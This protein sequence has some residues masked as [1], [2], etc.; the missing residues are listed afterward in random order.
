LRNIRLLVEFDGA[1]FSGWQYQPD[2]RTVQGE[3]QRAV[4]SVT[5][6]PATVYGCSRTDAGVSAR[7]YVA[8]FHAETPLPPDRLRL[9]LNYHLPPEILVKDAVEAP[10]GFHAR[11]SARSKTYV[12][13]LLRGRSPLRQHRAWELRWPV[14]PSRMARSL[15]R[16]VGTRDFQPFCLTR[17][18]SGTCAIFAA[19]LET[20]G[21]ELLVAVRGDRFLYKMVRR[22]VGA[23]V[24]CGAGRL[25]LADIRAALRGRTHRPF[26]TAPARGLTL[27]SVD[28]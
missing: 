8:N 25:T 17:D 19:G 1:G 4:A 3:L 7:N 27:D 18:R 12:Y 16:F 15:D 5:G 28:Y 20:A 9:A 26:Q 6:G 24:A 21:D 13:R 22:I 10:P 2:R 23:A 11:F 14:D